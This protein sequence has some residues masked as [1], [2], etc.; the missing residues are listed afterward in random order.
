MAQLG[1]KQKVD[2]QAFEN[3]GNHG[4]GVSDGVGAAAK[5]CF[6]AAC[7]GFHPLI[8]SGMPQK[9][10]GEALVALA[11]TQHNS[12]LSHRKRELVTATGYQHLC[13]G[14]TRPFFFKTRIEFTGVAHLRGS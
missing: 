5:R 2:M 12:G 9:K 7:L 3:V 1:K 10:F 13:E 14:H 11:S 4:K 8:S 6:D